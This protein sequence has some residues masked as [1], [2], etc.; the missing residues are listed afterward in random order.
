M[1]K[2]R[3]AHSPLFLLRYVSNTGVQSRFAAIVPVKVV[4]TAVGRNTL[5]RK[6][7][8]AVQKVYSRIAPGYKIALLAKSPAIT[9]SVTTI[10]ADLKDL[11][12]KAKL[13]Q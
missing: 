3:V 5:K 12:V 4:K 9:A 1:E 6:T 11:F 13:F 7:Y 10:E 2:G 8:E